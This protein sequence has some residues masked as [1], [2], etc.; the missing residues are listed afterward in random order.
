[1]PT[2]VDRLFSAAAFASVL[3]L[4]RAASAQAPELPSVEIVTPA[5]DEDAPAKGRPLPRDDRTGHLN[6][7]A[8]AGLVVPAGDLGAGLTL[9]QVANTGAGALVG[10]GIGITRHSGVD[11]R[12][13]YARLPRSAECPTCGTEMFAVGLGLVYHTSQALGFDPWVRFGAGYR[14][15]HVG[16]PLTSLLSTAPPPGTF[17]GIDVASFSLG[18]DFFPVRWFGLGLFF[19]GDVGVN[20]DAP[21]SAARGAVYGLFHAGLRIAL[22]PQRK[23]VTSAGSDP[24][25]RTAV[26]RY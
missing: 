6:V 5:E 16:G 17:H 11:L 3:L 21:S 20:A 13:Q 10:L 4:T 14:A 7:F 23:A 24:M 15:I 8:A 12:G 25:R 2:V 9:S 18:G 22:E 19:E 1:V 26:V